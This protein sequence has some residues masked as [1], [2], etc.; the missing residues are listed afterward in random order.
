MAID[1]DKYVSDVLHGIGRPSTSWIPDGLPDH[2]PTAGAALAFNPTEARAAWARTG[3][4]G[5]IKLV[6][7]N[8]ARN[9]V[10]FEFLADQLT[11][12][13]GA[14][15]VLDAVEPTTLTAMQKS[16]DTMP[17]I[18]IGGWCGDYPDPQNWMS[19]YWDSKAFAAHYGY[20]NETVDKLQRA[21]DGEPDILRRGQLY[22]DA[23][24]LVLDDVAVAPLFQSENVFLVKSYIKGYTV[25]PQDHMLGEFSITKMTAVR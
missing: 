18:T 21:A 16:L 15:I 19:V 25:T 14:K 5:D 23:E 7:A 11:Q 17:L 22:Q 24:K 9:R 1:R 10:R 6:Y 13:L 4:Q 8:A 20:K 12:H 2:N 3:Y